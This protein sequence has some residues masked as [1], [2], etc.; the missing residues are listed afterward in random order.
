MLGEL[1]R[2]VRRENIREVRILGGNF[3]KSLFDNQAGN[4]RPTERVDIELER[5]KAGRRIRTY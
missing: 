3:C 5:G 1:G 2:Q 4:L